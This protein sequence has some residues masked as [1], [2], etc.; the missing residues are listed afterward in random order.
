MKG[1]KV[2]IIISASVLM[3]LVIGIFIYVYILLE[4]INIKK[5]PNTNEELGISNAECGINDE[6]INTV[7]LP[8]HKDAKE[9]AD[10]TNIVLF[11]LDRRNPDAASRS[12]SIIVV[13]L[14]RKNEKVKVSSLMRDMYVQIPG[15]GDNR[16]NAA[17]AY[18]GPQLAIK[19]INSNF[20]LDIKNYVTVD[21][22]GCEKLIDK[23]G[24][25]DIDIKSYEVRELNDK[26]SEVDKI[27]G[28]KNTDYVSKP[29]FQT[30]DGRQAVAYSRIRYVGNA[31]Y[32]RTERQRMV[33]NEAF[34][35]IKAQ[36]L[37]K[38]P[39]T[40]ET[41]LPYVETSLSK[42]EIM[43]LAL[44]A[45]KFNTDD[46]VQFRL[47][48]NG[49]FISRNIRGMDVLVPNIEENKNLLHGFIYG[50]TE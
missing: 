23:L 21:F 20:G 35:K 47:P 14:D 3:A 29:G 7:P 38:F 13:S 28:N 1:K 6:K 36:G 49:Y 43:D 19:T 15:K 16:I 50:T 27:E 24:G 9:K 12:D 34:K 45:I 37:L 32:E 40:V 46:I 5:L 25:V 41:I 31:D 44:D 22:F 8:E 39:N 33:L 4:S 42:T 10:I 26:I 11:G 30:L 2:I 48:A 17:Y 18:G